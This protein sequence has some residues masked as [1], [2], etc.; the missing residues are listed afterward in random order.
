MSSAIGMIRHL[1]A[2]CRRCDRQ[3]ARARPSLNLTGPTDRALP[4]ELPVDGIYICAHG[5]ALTTEDDDPEGTLFELVRRIV[6]PEVPVVATFDLHANVSDRMV[7]LIDAFI[8]YRTNPHL[9]MRER[10]AEAAAALRELLA[11]AKTER[12]RLRL[13]IVPPT[14][15]MLT[16]A[17]PYAGMIE[18][19]QRKQN[20][21]HPRIMNVSVMG[22]FAYADTAKN[23][24]SV[25]VTSRGDRKAAE[26]LAREIAQYG[27]DNRARFY[28]K[29]TPL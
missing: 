22:G 19:G 4:A 2:S 26:A 14:V 12:V 29:L 15:T 16:A 7:D 18:L 28:P 11:G 23:G 13:P 10:G 6:G 1:R 27:W 3:C 21:L 20:E 5:A 8:G 9:D 24:L 25:I 17:G